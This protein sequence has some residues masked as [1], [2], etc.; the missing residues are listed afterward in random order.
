M[1]REDRVDPTGPNVSEARYLARC[2]GSSVGQGV[3]LQKKNYP[4][5]SGVEV[6]LEQ[7]QGGRVLPVALSL[8]TQL[9][10]R[11]SL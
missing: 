8:S 4:A 1:E 6:G 2:S 3:M 10:E 9:P 5:L 11:S 7:L